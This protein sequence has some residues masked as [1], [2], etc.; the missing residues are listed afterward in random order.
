MTDNIY[1]IFYVV[2]CNK[3]TGQSKVHSLHLD[4]NSA[5]EEIKKILEWTD[6]QLSKETVYDGFK[7]IDKDEVEEF[8]D[9]ANINHNHLVIHKVKPSLIPY[10]NCC[11]CH[12]VLVETKLGE[13]IGKL[14][15]ELEPQW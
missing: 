5:R 14:L 13:D 2:N 3:C 7:S 15:C 9:M 11:G 12:I 6:E 10:L 4:L 8:E 1:V